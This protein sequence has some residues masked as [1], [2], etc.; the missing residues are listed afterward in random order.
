MVKTNVIQSRRFGAVAEVGSAV[1]EAEEGQEAPVAC[2]I[3]A[4]RP[5][6]AALPLLRVWAFWFYMRGRRSALR[7]G[8]AQ[9]PED[10]ALPRCFYFGTYASH[11]LISLAGMFLNEHQLTRATCLILFMLNLALL[12]YLLL[13][14][15]TLRSISELF[16]YPLFAIIPLYYLL[17]TTSPFGVVAVGVMFMLFLSVGFGPLFGVCT[18]TT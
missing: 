4:G 11:L 18:R 13:P 2:R 17:D 3:E 5:R 1:A 8:A 10:V 6:A 12:I 9:A 14:S 15:R 16:A 7:Q